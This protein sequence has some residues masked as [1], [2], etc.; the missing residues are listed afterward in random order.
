M[1][2][3]NFYIKQIGTDDETEYAIGEKFPSFNMKSIS[4]LIVNGDPTNFYIESFANTSKVKVYV[5][6]KSTSIGTISMD[7]IFLGKNC[8]IDY[9]SFVDFISVSVLQYRD[10]YRNKIV[11]MRMSKAPKVSED[12]RRGEE[13][14]IDVTFT[15]ERLEL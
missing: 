11:K 4:G 2:Q 13:S 1:A 12:K 15:F 10:T 9:D 14:Y 8:E 6:E 3:Y 7:V 5:G